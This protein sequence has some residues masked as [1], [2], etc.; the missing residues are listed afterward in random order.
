MNKIEDIIMCK[1]TIETRLTEYEKRNKA[2]SK[3]QYIVKQYLG[4]SAL[5]NKAHRARAPETINKQVTARI[6]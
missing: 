5:Y 2:I 6:C 1:A 4:I 3:L